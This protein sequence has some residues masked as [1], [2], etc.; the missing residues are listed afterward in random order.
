[1]HDPDACPILKGRLGKPVKFGHK[2]QVVDNDDGVVLDHSVTPGN[3]VDAPQLAPAVER[4]TRRA[5]RPP[6]TV[7]AD[8]GYGEKRVE[9]DL[10]AAEVRTVLIPRRGKPGKARQA[11]EHRPAFRK[12]VKWRTGS[13]GR[14]SSLKR[15]YGWD[16]SRWTAPKER[17]SGRTRRP[18]PQPG[19]DRRFRLLT[20]TPTKIKTTLPVHVR[21]HD[22]TKGLL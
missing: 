17:G 11:H 15:G 12:T 18:G 16:H 21:T 4:V 1:L 6:R 9:D 22:A 13:E 10:H 5:G 8:C 20:G 7:T 14:I 3:P 19:Q 2:A